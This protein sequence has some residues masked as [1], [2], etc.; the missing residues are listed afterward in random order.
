MSE[1]LLSP[2][3]HELV[4]HSG[5][6][7]VAQFRISGC[8]AWSRSHHQRGAKLLLEDASG[9]T[10]AAVP[11][12]FVAEL[13]QGQPEFV[14]VSADVVMFDGRP[15][16]NV[17]SLEVLQPAELFSGA[18]LLPYRRCPAVARQA[19]AELIAFEQSLPDALQHFLRD[20]L[21]D[22]RIGLPLLDCR[23]SVSHHHSF[24]GGL[25]VH[26]MQL[27]GEAG[28][29]A[30]TALPNEPLAA[31]VT[32]LGYLLHDLGKIRSVGTAQRPWP[33]NDIQHEVSTLM[34]LDPH[35]QTLHA[36]D[37]AA[38]A[39]LAYILGYVATPRELRRHARFLGAEIVV[40]LDQLSVAAERDRDIDAV[41]RRH[42]VVTP[43][44]AANDPSRRS[45]DHGR[46]L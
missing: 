10:A 16:L 39:A 44:S 4:E 12:R 33:G 15:L 19:L 26:S 45:L 6:E 25:L 29:L 21:A 14:L 27:L 37:P 40:F 20:V 7:I 13:M 22:S 11:A 2:C 46:T 23:A 41:T 18:A 38:A 1:L 24:Q 30:S 17:N 42:S 32:Q 8:Q 9:V 36:R 3:I 43:I 34:L 28:R 5:K 31:P 35:L